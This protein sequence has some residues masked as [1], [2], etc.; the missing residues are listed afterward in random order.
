LRYFDT[1]VIFSLYI[2]EAR[3]PNADV[4]LRKNPADVAVSPWVDIELKSALSLGVRAGRLSLQDARAA[5]SDY[6]SDRT[7]GGYHLLAID[8]RHFIAA[9]QQIAFN[10]TLRAGDS[11]HLGIALVENCTFVTGDADLARLAQALGLVTVYV[12]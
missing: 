9:E 7:Q 12:A 8:T 1:S 10:N 5:L 11:L 2:N 4:E 6:R 3:T